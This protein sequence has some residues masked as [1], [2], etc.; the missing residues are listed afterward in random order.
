M[1]RY[2][3]EFS[4]V[5]A[6]GE[7]KSW[8]AKL[9]KAREQL[10]AWQQENTLPL[11]NLL[12]ETDDLDEIEALATDIRQRFKY[13]LVIGT[14]GS[15]LGA[16]VLVS[17]KQS[18]F[19][20]DDIT[21]RF[22]ENPDPHTVSDLLSHADWASTAMLIVSKSGSTVE[23]LSTAMICLRAMTDAL[24]ADALPKHCHFIT[25]PGDR[26]LRQMAEKLSCPV[27]DHDANIGGRYSVLSN[28]G[29]L[30]AAIAGID[31]RAL[32]KGAAAT[33]AE[34]LAGN[35][36]PACQGAVMQTSLM[37][38]KPISVMMPYC[39]RLAP[40]AAWHQQLWAESLG[41]G[42]HGSTL[43][44]ALGAIDQHS[45]LQ[46]YL[47]GP[48]DK[49]F[50]LITLDHAGSGATIEGDVPEAMHYLTG[51]QIGTVMQSLQHGTLETMKKHGLPLRE[52]KL[53]QL[54]EETLGALLMHF[55]LET[56]LAAEL[57]GVNAFDQ[58][59]VE[60]GKIIAREYLAR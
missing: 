32:R 19:T 42:G 44:R 7:Y 2:H 47:D 21:I 23:P 53:A 15:S 40:L 22:L 58:P 33:L 4:A 55:M 39:D 37:Q 59:A 52:I 50:T 25:M 10:T 13:V 18:E 45:Q 49:S 48:K 20:H 16:K 30:P 29:L 1:P 31:I 24:G 14:G 9:T 54:D 17:L 5:P 6:L 41:K 35:D 46:L 43:V 8:E 34:T 28:V 27:L 36:A 57:I 51:H 60:E 38:S 3:Q 56:M 12:T 26:P 11:L